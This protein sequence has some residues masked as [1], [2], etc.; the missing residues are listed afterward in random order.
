MNGALS[1]RRVPFCLAVKDD[2]SSNYSPAVL[3]LYLHD[4]VMYD[5]YISADNTKKADDR[6]VALC[7]RLFAS[8]TKTRKKKKKTTIAVQ[9][10][11]IV[12]VSC[13]II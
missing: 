7:T 1:L 5:R 11:G 12:I 2:R 10:G 9:H 13:R 8:C 3:R 4:C 6:P